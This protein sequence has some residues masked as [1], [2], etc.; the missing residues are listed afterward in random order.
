MLHILLSLGLAIAGANLTFVTSPMWVWSWRGQP[1]PRSSMP[2][3]YA[4]GLVVALAGV[5]M[6]Y[7]GTRIWSHA[8]ELGLYTAGIHL[9]FS[10]KRYQAR[11]LTTSN[12]ATLVTQETSRAPD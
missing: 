2:L 4:T 6:L 11:Q 5:L 8:W 10:V 12:P 1:E 7:C 3:V 9:M